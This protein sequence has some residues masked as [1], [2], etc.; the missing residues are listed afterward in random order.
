MLAAFPLAAAAITPQKTLSDLFVTSIA[1]SAQLFQRYVHRDSVNTSRRG[2]HALGN[3]EP[4]TAPLAWGEAEAYTLTKVARDLK[5]HAE[6]KVQNKATRRGLIQALNKGYVVDLSCHGAFNVDAS[7]Q[8]TLR[9][10]R[11]EKL[12]LGQILSREVDL[13]GLRLLILS[14]CQTAILD[15]RGASDEVRSLATGMLQAGADAVLASL[16]PVDDKAT[17]LL[18]VRFAQEWFPNMGNEPPAA[19]LARAQHWLRNVTNGELEQWEM[20][21]RISSSA[22]E[23]G[24]QK[25]SKVAEAQEVVPAAMSTSMNTNVLR[26]YRYDISEAIQYIRNEARDHGPDAR[27]YEDPFFWAGFQITGW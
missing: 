26:G 24:W 20:M 14:A 18:M 19:A 13:Q 25:G 6:V 2:I 22:E 5:L 11:G 9:L 16:W 1:P 17:Y 23:N 12:T 21:M 4:Q 8:S 27:P 10:S 7:L 3:P 15:L